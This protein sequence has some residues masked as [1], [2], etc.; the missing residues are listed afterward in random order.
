VLSLRVPFRHH[1]YHGAEGQLRSPGGES[2]LRIRR[3]ELLAYSVMLP[4]AAQSD[5]EGC[6]Q[7][8]CR[9]DKLKM[10]LA[11][12]L[13]RRSSSCLP[14]P[15]TVTSSHQSPFGA[16]PQHG[17]RSGSI[18]HARD[19]T[20]CFLLNCLLGGHI[21]QPWQHTCNHCQRPAA[22]VDPALPVTLSLVDCD[23][24]ASL[25]AA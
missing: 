3:H 23:S 13:Q 18:A 10:S 12:G 22:C 24:A 1:R 2:Q 17:L 5:V 20:A 14:T 19:V 8:Q 25:I 9:H 4:L 16:M 11:P 15:S 21:L 6:Q 7:V